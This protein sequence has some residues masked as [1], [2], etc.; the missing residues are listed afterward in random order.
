MEKV[1]DLFAGESIG[2]LQ[3]AI[4]MVNLSNMLAGQDFSPLF[5]QTNS[6]KCEFCLLQAA[7][8]VMNTCFSLRIRKQA[9]T[10]VCGL[11]DKRMLQPPDQ[12]KKS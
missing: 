7:G 8:Q 2:S 11:S 3:S 4:K 9:Y 12:G 6:R 10:S 1:S 5:W